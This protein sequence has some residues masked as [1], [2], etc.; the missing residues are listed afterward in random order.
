MSMKTIDQYMT[1]A[2]Y[3]VAP[4]DTLVK[5]KEMMQASSVRHLPVLDGERVVGIVTLSDLFVMEAIVAADPDRTI[6][7]EAMSKELYIVAPSEPLANVASEMARRSVGSAI[8]VDRGK[9]V[10]IF[11]STDACRVLGEVLKQ[12]AT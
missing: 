4:G 10:G 3:T 12:Q 11:T 5:A 1:V 8:V 7:E 6:V 2:R 9:L